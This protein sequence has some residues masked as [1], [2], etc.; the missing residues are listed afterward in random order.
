MSR[1]ERRSLLFATG[2]IALLSSPAVLRAQ[3]AWPSQPIRLICPFAAGGPTDVAARLVAEQ[4]TPILRQRVVVENRTG[5][6]VVVGT[7]VVAKARDGYT[8]LYSTIAHAV[9]RPLFAN[10]SFDPINDF[11]P[12]SLVGVIPMLMQVNNNFPA[13]DLKEMIALVRDN[14][15][16]YNYGSSGTGG[17]VHLATELF[18]KQAGDLKMNHIPYRGSAPAMPDLLNGSLAML[19]NVASDG[20]T[21]VQSGQTRGLAISSTQRVPQLPNVPSFAEAGLPGYEAYTWH[22]VFAPAGVPTEVVLAMNDAVNRVTGDPRMQQRFADMTMQAR[23]NT[24]PEDAANW[25]RSE[26][27]KWEPM[28]KAAGIVAQ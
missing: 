25:L 12:I 11:Q 5:A 27:A 10:L 13:K 17:A 24:S 18:L 4:L 15:G 3:S 2:G 9:L 22:M 6:G 28:V 8:F 19:L 26:T 1:I 14:P 20:V 23:P 16:K 7:E 21:S